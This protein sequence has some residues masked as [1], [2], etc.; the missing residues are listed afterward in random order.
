M[1]VLSSTIIPDNYKDPKT[2]EKY[3]LRDYVKG[4]FLNTGKNEYMSFYYTAGSGLTDSLYDKIIVYVQDD[5]AILAT[6]EID[7]FSYSFSKNYLN[8]IKSLEKKLGKWN[9]Y[10]Y[11]CDLNKNGINE[12]FIFYLTGM[13]FVL[14]VYEYKDGKFL[15][16]ISSTDKRAY[17]NIVTQIDID[18]DNSR[19]AVFGD[20]GKSFVYKWNK[21]KKQYEIF[22]I[23]P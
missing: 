1:F 8:I 13:D 11:L 16:L 4:N 9:G 5:K 15:Q 6:C 3:I 23:N 14:D 2:N 17:L 7:L 19:L 12:I 22:D 20:G 18:L 10:F 21:V